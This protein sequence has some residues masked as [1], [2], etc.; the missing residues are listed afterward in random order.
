M[1]GG[2]YIAFMPS[3]VR[4]RA[5]LLSLLSCS[6]LSCNDDGGPPRTEGITSD[7]ALFAHIT[8][9]DPY[10]AYSPFPGVDSVA[11]GS[12]NGSNAHQPLV[13]VS[14][15]ATALS[16]LRNDTLPQGTAFPDGSAIVKQIITNGQTSLLAVMFKDRDNSFAGN[17]WLWAEYQLDGQPFIPMANRGAACV[18]CHLREQGPRNDLVRTFERRN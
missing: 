1:T 8:R 5:V 13:R 3:Y 10:T 15:N 17:G 14:M 6:L 16:A 4:T 7:S 9:A 2:L 12:L 18:D 11:S